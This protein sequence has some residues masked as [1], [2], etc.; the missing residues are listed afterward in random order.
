MH[1]GFYNYIEFILYIIIYICVCVWRGDV[2]G[3]VYKYN[4]KLVNILL[5]AIRFIYN[6]ILT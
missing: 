4:H 6:M 5:I 2:G 1:A 3:S